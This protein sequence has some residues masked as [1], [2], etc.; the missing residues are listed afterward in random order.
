MKCI[1]K[2]RTNTKRTSRVYD[3]AATPYARVMAHK[4]IRAS[5]KK[6]L[7]AFHETLDVSALRKE[8]KRLRTELFKGA[9]FTKND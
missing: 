3:T 6:K 7:K 9:R 5:V 4:Y 1:E 2:H 8:I